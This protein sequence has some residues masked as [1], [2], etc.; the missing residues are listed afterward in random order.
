MAFKFINGMFIKKINKIKKNKIRQENIS[1]KKNEVYA[2][3]IHIKFIVTFIISS[4][5]INIQPM[6]EK[7]LCNNT[8]FPKI[9]LSLK[10]I[11]NCVHRI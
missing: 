10:A 2:C 1:F 3:I 11:S 8:T 7:N 5:L 9:Y 4:R 6:R